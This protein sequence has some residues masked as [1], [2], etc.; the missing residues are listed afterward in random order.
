L[1]IAVL[2]GGA[3][4]T[5][6][7]GL[8]ATGG[9]EPRFVVRSDEA[10]AAIAAE[11]LTLDWPDRSLRVM[12]KC[13]GALADAAADTVLVAVRSY[14]TRAAAREIAACAP[15]ATVISF[16]NGVGNEAVLAET[17]PDAAVHGATLTAAVEL[18]GAGRARVS[19][20]GG[21]AV[22]LVGSRGASTAA[23]EVADWLAR[24]GGIVA[25]TPSEASLKWSK[26]L[27]NLI[28]V[29]SSAILGQPP[30]Q[31]L[32]HRDVLAIERAAFLEALAVMSAAGVRPIPLPGY[33][34][35]ALAH[36][37][38]LVPLTVLRRL[39]PRLVGSGR[40]GKLPGMAQDVRRGDGRTE[41]GVLHGAVVAAGRRA[42]VETPVNDAL[43]ALVTGLAGRSIDPGP[44]AIHPEALTVAVRHSRLSRADTSGASA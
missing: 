3:V 38:P 1:T 34:V 25:T 39:A 36:I 26:L 33:R 11:G 37:L 8:L 29:A 20:R 5:W 32:R 41:V 6:L 31:A 7:A 35:D 4:G 23:S 2:G 13:V 10:R 17:L 30:G 28:G 12:V 16:Q 18:D 44:L 9:A 43:A 14:D 22:C 24:G 42:G 27:L 21:A 40:A 15:R 19:S